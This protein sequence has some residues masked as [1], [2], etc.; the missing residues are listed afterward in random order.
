MSPGVPLDLPEVSR[1][2]ALG[3]PVI[4]EL[5]LAS[6]WLRGPV[7]AIT[8][9]KGKSTTTTLVGRMLEAAGRRVL[10]GGNIGVP[11]SAQVDQSTDDTVHVVEASSF[12]LEATDRVP[13]VDRGAAQFLARSPGPASRRSRVRGRQDPHLRQPAIE[14]LGGGQCRQL[15]GHAHGGG[16]PRA[17]RAVRRGP[18][19]PRRRAR[20]PRIRVA[21][22]VG[23]RRAAA[24]AG[25]GAAG[26]PPHAQQRGGRDGDQPPGRRDG[27]FAWRVRST[28]SP[29]SST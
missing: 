21:P 11:L 13:P 28:G 18:S 16:R 20:E 3:V 25:R 23:R 26:G 24:A 14:G 9:T 10:V 8:G 17:S 15:R 27:R 12:Q 19:R 6:R 4:G 22:H 7:V 1:A 29:V 2:R 5:E